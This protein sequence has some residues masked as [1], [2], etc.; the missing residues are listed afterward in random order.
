MTSA[1]VAATLVVGTAAAGD[2]IAERYGIVIE[3]TEE[4]ADPNGS[5]S[6][7]SVVEELAGDDTLLKFLPGQYYVDQQ[8]CHVGFNNFEMVGHDAELVGELPR[9]RR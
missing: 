1:A 5:E 9:L 6:I 8:V 2:D 3:V 7:M 4:G